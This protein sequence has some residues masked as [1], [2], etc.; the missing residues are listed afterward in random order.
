M[1]LEIV[2]FFSVE[3][4]LTYVITAILFCILATWLAFLSV[5]RAA[6]SK[7]SALAWKIGAVLS[8]GIGV[9]GAHF[10]AVL[11][12]RPDIV[13]G[14]DLQFTIVSTIV[15]IAGNGAGILMLLR[16]PGKLWGNLGGLT[17][18]LSTTG[19]HYIGVSGLAGCIVSYNPV[20]IAIVTAIICTTS[21]CAFTAFRKLKRGK[22]IASTVVFAV[23]V[24]ILHFGAMAGTTTIPL[25]NFND[26]HDLSRSEIA[27]V[28]GGFAGLIAFLGLAYF[29]LT[30]LND[31]RTRIMALVTEQTSDAIVVLDDTNRIKWANASFVREFGYSQRELLGK[32]PGKLLKGP[33][34]DTETVRQIIARAQEGEESRFELCLYRKNGSHLWSDFSITPVLD[35]KGRNVDV[36]LLVSRNITSLKQREAELRE[37]QEKARAG[38]KAKAQFLANMSHEIR[39]PMNGVMG[40]AEL[41]GKTKLDDRQNTFVNIIIKSGNSLLTIINDILDFSKIDAGQMELDIAPFCLSDAINDVTTLVSSKAAEKDLELIVRVDPKLPATAIG[42]VGRIR[43]IITNLVGNAVKFTEVGHVFVE[44][45]GEKS[46]QTDDTITDAELY[47]LEFRITDTGIGIPEEKCKK[48]FEQFSQVDESATRKHDGTGL[49]LAIS[50][51][52]VELMNGTIGVESEVGKGTTFW[53]KVPLHC[54]EVELDRPCIDQ[55]FEGARILVVDDNEVNRLIM[56][57]QTAAWGFEGVSVSSGHE[58]LMFLEKASSFGVSVDA[59]ILDYQMPGMNGEDVARAI[60]SRKGISDIPIIMLTSVQETADGKSFRS[61]DI[62]EHLTKPARSS[63]LLDATLN[64]LYRSQQLREAKPDLQLV[65]NTPPLVEDEP[66]ET[67]EATLQTPADVNS[68]ETPVDEDTSAT[69]DSEVAVGETQNTNPV[70]SA[71]QL[72]VLICEDN[73][74]NQIVFSQ[75]LSQSGYSFTIATN[76]RLGLEMYKERQPRLILMDISMPEMNGREATQAIRE[77][78]AG[79]DRHTPIIAVTAHAI[80]GDEEAC[81]EAGMDDYLSKPVSPQALESAIN[82]WLQSTAGSRQMAS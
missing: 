32:T 23:G 82:K 63:A 50:A 5:K 46:G 58:A 28:A 70:I 61:L 7:N 21:V 17:T 43:Q 24:A 55:C 19:M 41:L 79:T 26:A 33:D 73:E 59:I 22:V 65:S 15:S 71:P 60:R 39:T 4:V 64:V 8:L 3:H 53:F 80:N 54:R 25:M 18:G 68:P 27:W 76:G 34:T 37:S 66:L 35:N 12:Y 52:L 30:M 45:T 2:S 31:A 49:G 74:V 11:G 36:Y 75:I 56:D 16:Q 1:L 69:M 29:R 42:D 13:F 47:D 44:V 38:E 77:I 40:M 48:V 51:S 81:L 9:W 67:M 62:Q 6:E 10:I 72:D 20:S 78:E 14:F 57:E